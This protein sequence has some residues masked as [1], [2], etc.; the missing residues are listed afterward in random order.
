MLQINEE[1]FLSNLSQLAEIGRVATAKGGG[2]DR[3]PFSDSDRQA[4]AFFRQI[5]SKADLKVTTDGVANLSARV[6]AP[7]VEARTV[8]FGSHLDTVPHGGPVD[9]AL[10]VIAALETLCTMREAGIRSKYHLEAIAFTDE[11]G[12]FGDLTGS[13]VATGTYSVEQIARF[14]QNAEEFPD[15]LAAMRAEVAGGLS[16]QSILAAQRDLSQIEAFVE[17]HIEQGPQLE[18]AGLPIGVVDTIFGRSSFEVTFHGRSD[19]AGTTPL[20]LRA[21]ALVAAASF[22]TSAQDLVRGQ[23]P[24]AVLTCGNAVVR[25]GVYNVVSNWTQLLL[26]F[27]AGSAAELD[28]VDQGVRGLL[29]EIT[30]PSGL[31]YTMV[32]TAQLEPRAMDERIQRV[33][34][35]ATDDLGY[36]QMSFSSGALHDAHSLAPYVPTGMIF[37]PSVGRA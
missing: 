1:R 26:E 6:D 37:V 35:Q 22:I 27:R 10:G 14:L 20:G 4:R 18:H 24:G 28:G 30:S 32:R 21:D 7:N 36:S 12:R 31:T 9:G 15:D 8:L 17:L 5:A 34:Q 23:Y 25:P 3:R 33:I 11:E 19:H 13:Q 29:D 2:L 16:P